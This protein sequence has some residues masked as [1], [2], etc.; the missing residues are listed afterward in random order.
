MLIPKRRCLNSSHKF[1]SKKKKS[2][3]KY[4]PNNLAEYVTDSIP[5]LSYK[6]SLSEIDRLYEISWGQF[7]FCST[8]CTYNI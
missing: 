6:T 7:T 3:E 4:K 8:F 5:F 2:S 1:V